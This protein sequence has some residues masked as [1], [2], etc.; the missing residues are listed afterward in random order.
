MT[1]IGESNFLHALGWAVLNSLWQMA[2]LWVVYQFITGIIRP[3]TSLKKSSFASVLII[4]G[5][6]WFIYTFFSIL[7]GSSS[8]EAA[9]STNLLSITGNEELNTWLNVTL[10][11]ASITYMMLL[12]FPI[13]HFGKN[14]RYVQLIR[15]TGLSKINV[16]WRMFVRKVSA[17]MGIKKPVHIWV[18]ELVSSP[19]TIGYLKPV[20][21]VPLAAINHLTPQQLEAV[22][23]H[24]LSHIRRYDY[25]I[26]LIINFIQTILYFNP[27]VKAFV[28]VV[29]REREKSCDEM[30]MQFQYDPHGYASALLM[31][32]KVNY[33]PKPLAVAVGGK[34][35]DLL[36]RIELILGVNKKSIIPFNKIAGL[37]ASLLCIIG[38][39]ALVL[40]SKPTKGNE[41]ANFAG[42]TSPFYFFADYNASEAAH[43][44]SNEI[45][46]ASIVN[47]T[48]KPGIQPEDKTLLQPAVA[49][50][51]TYS[52][53]TIEV[54]TPAYINV[55]YSPVVLPELK[56]YEE[57]QVKQTIE[58]SKKVIEDVQWKA[59]EKNLADAFTDKEKEQLKNEYLKEVSKFDWNQWENKLKLAYDNIDW[60]KINEQLGKA[61]TM[62]RIDSL[63]KVYSVAAIELEKVQ[64]QLTAND[65]KGIPDSDISL[66]EIQN[67]KEQ[68]LK[69]STNL[70]DIRAKKIIRL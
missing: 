33:F 32:E 25:L 53:G 36:H 55:N 2:L 44:V 10:P 20:I 3:I 43:N 34:R 37:F 50:E 59:A 14:Y 56:K 52:P 19:V 5:F 63:Q 47:H 57:E 46:I 35:N 66:K 64:Q 58:A 60:D 11:I 15:N 28:K 54:N 30:V 4:A 16:E 1:A 26:N 62:I 13:L 22:L 27:F 31:L 23:L 42:I 21:L 45:K 6:A 18:S 8:S 68:L 49:S 7:T 65:L 9:I 61:V 12:V 48:Q 40:F 51:Y 70:K 41:T 38:L 17:Q 69:L 67:K 24:E 29:E 39:N